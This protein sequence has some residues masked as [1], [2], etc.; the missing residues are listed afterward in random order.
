[1]R[2]LLFFKNIYKNAFQKQ[3]GL[4]EILSNLGTFEDCVRREV[5]N[6]L[7]LVTSGTLPPNP[8][9]LIGSAAMANFLR[10][11][12]DVYDYIFVDT[13]PVCVV[14]DALVAA[15]LAAGV[16]LVC[17][18]RQT[19]YTELQNAI[20]SIHSVQSNLLGVV[21][22]DVKDD[23]STYGRYDR[24]RYYKSYDYAYISDAKK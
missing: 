5:A 16:V 14:S 15:G 22:T 11:M 8:S 17:R 19:T 6:N 4:S 18:Q 1:M 9:E 2:A 23:A 20:E 3:N 21:I 7:D 24:Y 13:P 10:D 12:E